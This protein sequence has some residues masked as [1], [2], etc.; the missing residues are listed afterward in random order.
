MTTQLFEI[1]YPTM[2]FIIVFTRFKKRFF[3]A[4]HQENMWMIALLATTEPPAR[5]KD[6]QLTALDLRCNKESSKILPAKLSLYACELVL[7]HCVIQIL[8]K[9]SPEIT[10]FHSA[11]LLRNTRQ[12]HTPLILWKLKSCISYSRV[13]TIPDEPWYAFVPGVELRLWCHYW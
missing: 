4:Q 2:S 13:F 6:F 5:L 12:G 8:Y 9:S 11:V 10:I 3:L 1:S 7:V